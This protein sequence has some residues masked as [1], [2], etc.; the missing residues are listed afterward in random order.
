[1]TAEDAR[2]LVGSAAVGRTGDP[3]RRG[4]RVAL[5]ATDLGPGNPRARPA[6]RRAGGP[7]RRVRRS[8]GEGSR[9]R[10]TWRSSTPPVHVE[11]PRGDTAVRRRHRAPG[12]VLPHRPDQPRGGPAFYR[13][14][15]G[16]GR[17]SG[18]CSDDEDA[19]AK[20]APR[21]VTRSRRVRGRTAVRGVARARPRRPGGARMVFA[22]WD[23]RDPGRRGDAIRC[24][25]GSCT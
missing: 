12:C 22:G 1:M 5:I 6:H 20:A 15:V 24:R 16:A 13:A 10:T 11:R 18:P 14:H 8:V 4:R 2:A 25:C 7:S 3:R 21:P 19:I 23:G 9:T 17:A